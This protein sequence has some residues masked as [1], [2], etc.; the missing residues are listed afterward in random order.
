MFRILIYGL[1]IYAI[2]RFLKSKGSPLV[3]RKEQTFHDSTSVKEAELIQDP[4]C[5]AYF[6]KQNGVKARVQG[7]TLYFCSETCRDEYLKSHQS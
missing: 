7:H 4:Q 1:L 2:Y 3:T 6:L 5:G